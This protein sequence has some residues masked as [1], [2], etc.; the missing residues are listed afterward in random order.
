MKK[1]II[2]FHPTHKELCCRAW[3]ENVPLIS[4]AAEAVL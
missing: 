1:K 4:V 3:L 2:S